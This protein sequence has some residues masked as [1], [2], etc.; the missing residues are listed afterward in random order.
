MQIR[1]VTIS[2]DALFQEISGEGVILDLASSSYFGLDGVGVRLWQLL[3]S[4]SNLEAACQQLINEYEVD[5]EQLREDILTL[6]GQLSEAGLVIV[7]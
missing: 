3:Q 5:L 7:E 4:D 1:S 6:V 2:P